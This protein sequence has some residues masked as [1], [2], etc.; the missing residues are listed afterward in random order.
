MYRFT[1][2]L[3]NKSKLT[4][5]LK[6]G[7][8]RIVWYDLDPDKTNRKD[9]EFLYATLLNYKDVEDEWTIGFRMEFDE[10]KIPKEA[11]FDNHNDY[12]S[13]IKNFLYHEI[14][15]F[16]IPYDE[17]KSVYGIDSNEWNENYYR[18]EDIMLLD[19]P[20]VFS[21]IMK[22]IEKFKPIP[23]K[24][25]LDYIEEDVEKDIY[26]KEEVG[27]YKVFVDIPTTDDLAKTIYERFPEVNPYNCSC[28]TIATYYKGKGWVITEPNILFNEYINIDY[29][30]DKEEK[31]IIIDFSKQEL[32]KYMKEKE[33]EEVEIER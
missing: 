16:I 20:D 3:Y 29:E 32:D 15:F 23:F 13:A 10:N 33:K 8:K 12:L 1:T 2:D 14:D 4:G 19:N 24:P 7:N 5:T 27:L 25:T 17:Y 11:E 6:D 28:E 22:D 30:F 9:T 21:D 18:N 26:T 31:Q